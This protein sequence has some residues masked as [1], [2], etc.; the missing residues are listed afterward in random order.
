MSQEERINGLVAKTSYDKEVVGC[1][2]SIYKVVGL[3]PV[4]KCGW[5]RSGYQCKSLEV[6][7]KSEKKL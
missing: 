5:C 1:Y 3:C 2:T 4:S 6:L 7:E